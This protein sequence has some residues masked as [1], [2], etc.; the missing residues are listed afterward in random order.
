MNYKEIADWLNERD[1]K[2]ARGKRFRNAHTHSILKKKRMSDD[3][4][5]RTFLSEITNC[6]IEHFDKSILNQT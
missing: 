6:S 1:I 3:K 4:F 2:T 5:S